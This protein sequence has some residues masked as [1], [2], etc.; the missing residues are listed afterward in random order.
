MN[1]SYVKDQVA[2][3]EKFFRSQPEMIKTKANHLEE[4]STKDAFR[5]LG[6]NGNERVLDLGAGNCW[7]SQYIAEIGCR[8]VAFDYNLSDIQGLRVGRQLIKEGKSPYFDTVCG[9]WEKLPFRTEVFD[10]IFCY[11]SLHHSMNLDSLLGYLYTVLKKGGRIIST[12]DP[13]VPLYVL[14][15]KAYA[16]KFQTIKMQQGIYDNYYSVMQYRR[17]YRRAGFSIQVITTASS[18]LDFLKSKRLGIVSQLLSRMGISD[19]NPL[20][21]RLNLLLQPIFLHLRRQTIT[22]VGLKLN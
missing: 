22:I 18:P 9:D 17:A 16:Q 7:A 8:V 21:R 19:N 13:T 12:G 6:L 2:V 15:R 10:V 4:T 3:R 5:M 14:N 1:G 20:L 11:Q